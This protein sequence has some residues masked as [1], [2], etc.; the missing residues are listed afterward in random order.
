MLTFKGEPNQLVR[1]NPPI[2]LLKY[3][4]FD[5]KGEY[6]TENERVIKRFHHHFDS[7]PTPEKTATPDMTDDLEQ[8]FES[9]EPSKQWR[10]DQCEFITDNKGVLLKHKKAEHPK[11]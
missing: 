9:S 7:V 5:D 10:C 2:G 3:A 8:T 11:E 4:R 1:L 6:T